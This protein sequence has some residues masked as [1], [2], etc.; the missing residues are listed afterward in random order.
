MF[1]VNSADSLSCAIP[2]SPLT[3]FCVNPNKCE[4]YIRLTTRLDVAQTH[5]VNFL[6]II[7]CSEN[8]SDVSGKLKLIC[9]PVHSDYS[10]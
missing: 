5:M 8:E 3:G 1:V 9:C 10:R 4:A 7:T 2:H 6:N